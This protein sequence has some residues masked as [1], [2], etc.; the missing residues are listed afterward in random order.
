MVV[1]TGGI[2]RSCRYAD[3]EAVGRA[4]L[5]QGGRLGWGVWCWAGARGVDRKYHGDSCVV[6]GMIMGGSERK[7]KLE[8]QVRRC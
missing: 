6:T 4:G 7:E 2:Y 5:Q 3:G 8:G 1:A